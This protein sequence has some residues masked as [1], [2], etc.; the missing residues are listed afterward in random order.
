M[1]LCVRLNVTV[2]VAAGC[3][4]HSRQTVQ[5]CGPTRDGRREGVPDKLGLLFP[6]I[7]LLLFLVSCFLFL[8]SLCRQFAK[9]FSSVLPSSV[10]PSQEMVLTMFPGFMGTMHG[11]DASVAWRDAGLI[12]T[13]VPIQR[14]V[15]LQVHATN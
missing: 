8:V 2:R 6:V 1:C 4:D 9:C 7:I 5:P 15:T 13:F 14:S 11:C 12:S 10:I 3:V